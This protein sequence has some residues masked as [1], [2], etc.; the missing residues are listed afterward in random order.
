M[1]ESFVVEVAIGIR[2]YDGR[3]DWVASDGEDSDEL[4][5]SIE[6]AKDAAL[7]RYGG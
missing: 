7:I 3:Y 5:D 6:K 2:E 4:Y 1:V